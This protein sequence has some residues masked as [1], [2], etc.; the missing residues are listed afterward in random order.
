MSEEETEVSNQKLFSF[1]NSNDVEGVHSFLKNATTASVNKPDK[2]GYTPLIAATANREGD[3]QI[4]EDFLSFEGIDVT[5]ANS[6]GNTA[7][8]YFCQNGRGDQCMK[9]FNKFLKLGA[10]INA[11]NRHGET[12]LF[13]AIF[14]RYES[15]AMVQT[16]LHHDA[17]VDIATK[18][19][20]ETV[21][22]Y[23]VRLGREDLVYVLV[24]AGAPLNVKS[25]TEE[26]TP[27]EMACRDEHTTNVANYLAKIQGIEYSK[28]RKTGSGIAKPVSKVEI[29]NPEMR[30]REKPKT[31][32]DKKNSKNS[33]ISKV[34][35]NRV[36]IKE[37]E[38]SSP[39]GEMQHKTHVDIE[40]NW[41]GEQD[42][43][44]AFELVEKVGEGAFGAVF[45]AI[46][47]ETQFTIAIKKVPLGAKTSFE[48]AIKK[49]ISIL[50]QCRHHFIVQYYGCF[51]KEQHLWILMDFCKRGSIE[52]L[53]QDTPGRTLPEDQISQFLY[54]ALEGL[55]YL[56]SRNIIHRDVKAANLLRTEEGYVK[57]ADFGVSSQIRQINSQNPGLM[58]SYSRKNVGTPLW[59]AP[60]VLLQTGHDFKADIW[61]LGITAIEMAD[62]RPPHH[63]KNLMRAMAIIPSSPPPLLKNPSAWTQE[64]N[65]FLKTCLV[66]DHKERPSSILLLNHEFMQIGKKKLEEKFKKFRKTPAPKSYRATLEL[67]SPLDIDEGVTSPVSSPRDKKQAWE[68]RRTPGT[69]AFHQDESPENSP[70][71]VILSPEKGSD[72]GVYK[73]DGEDKKRPSDVSAGHHRN[74]VDG[75]RDALLQDLSEFLSDSTVDARHHK[76]NSIGLDVNSTFSNLIDALISERTLFQT[77]QSHLENELAVNKRLMEQLERERQN[78]QKYHSVFATIKEAINAVG[79]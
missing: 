65:D 34:R 49:E 28:T 15:L 19:H 74:E 67:E 21:L 29:K 24:A 40:Y 33:L 54:A 30:R 4:I 59:M 35:K 2:N 66:I 47:I 25:S 70:N 60:E 12:P 13:K 76:L 10:D 61:S 38:I 44:S 51:F 31:E 32:R 68:S 1:I 8:H 56:H 26:M 62:G 45:R 9:T 5:L 78:L 3:P 39:Q 42:P 79:E 20:G 11:E 53:L 27:F 14:N 55:S 75:E 48:E 50:K 46:H 57:L 16:L 63:E 18:Q 17:R 52:D 37:F 73:L 43:E 23:A 71:S 7:L 58:K 6:D 22:H 77:L 41:T 64:F 36:N 69:D 72:D